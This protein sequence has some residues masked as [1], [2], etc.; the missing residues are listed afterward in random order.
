MPRRDIMNPL[1]VTIDG[2]AGL[3]KS[4]VARSLAARLGIPYLNSGAL[5]RAVAW[6][7]SKRGIKPNDEA[8]VLDLCK[9]TEF[10]LVGPDNDQS[11]VIDGTRLT[12]ELW[13]PHVSLVASE[14]SRLPSVRAF[15]RPIQRQCGN[16]QGVVA[17]GRDMGTHVFVDAEVKVFLDA[18]PTVRAR[19]RFRELQSRDAAVSWERTASELTERDNR[20]TTR[21]AAPLRPSPD[22]TMIDTSDLS[23]SQVVD[24]ILALIRQEQA[25]PQVEPTPPVDTTK[26]TQSSY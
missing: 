10:V 17:E 3:G 12:H 15:L 8:G 26:R 7:V 20:D 11:V 21:D 25:R 13:T 22:A 1:T 6:K 4:T 23:A 18:S 9:Q 24:A 16:N 5:Y 14:V 19:R 2:P